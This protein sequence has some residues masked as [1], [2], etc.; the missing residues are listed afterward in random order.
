MLRTSLSPWKGT[1]EVRGSS[2]MSPV[3]HCPE[4]KQLAWPSRGEPVSCPV[5]LNEI[6]GFIVLVSCQMATL[7]G[8]FFTESIL[9]PW[10]QFNACTMVAVL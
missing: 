10:R 1:L 6:L 7:L 8:H 4:Q 3:L 9:F 2:H 5:G